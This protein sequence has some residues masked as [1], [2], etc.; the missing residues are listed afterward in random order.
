MIDVEKMYDYLDNP[1]QEYRDLLKKSLDLYE[2]MKA[3]VPADDRG[4]FNDYYIEQ[5]SVRGEL[6]RWEL[7]KVYKGGFKEGFVSCREIF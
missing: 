7:I 5:E 1:D 2:K 3:L 6:T 4:I